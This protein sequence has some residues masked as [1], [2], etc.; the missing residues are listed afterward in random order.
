MPCCFAGLLNICP[1]NKVHK[2]PA[3]QVVFLPWLAF[4]ETRE[5]MA[6]FCRAFGWMNLL[7]VA[8][9]IALPTAP[10]WFHDAYVHTPQTQ[11]PSYNQKG[12]P[13]GLMRVDTVLESKIF[14]NT[15]SK[16]PVVYGAFP[17]MHCGWPFIFTL[18]YTGNWQIVIY[19]YAI[20]L[21]WSAMYLKHHYLTDVLGGWAYAYLAMKIADWGRPKR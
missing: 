2:Y 9:Q 16:S 13:A 10:P 1:V 4:Y 20:L 14:D 15:Y 6:S 12:H 3:R 11:L 18:Y 7:A 8:T 19:G 21:A 17:S 5:N